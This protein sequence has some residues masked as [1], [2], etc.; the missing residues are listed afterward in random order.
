MEDFFANLRK[1]WFV[2]AA[3]AINLRAELV[4]ILID[5]FSITW[6]FIPICFNI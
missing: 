4:A 2:D 5:F 6:K 1:L 3:D